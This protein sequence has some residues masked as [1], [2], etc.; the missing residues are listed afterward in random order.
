MTRDMHSMENLGVKAPRLTELTSR[1]CSVE[2]LQAVIVQLIHIV[3]A[4][5]KKLE[6]KQDRPWRATL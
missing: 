5:A 6:A 4:N 3:N 1:A 2:E